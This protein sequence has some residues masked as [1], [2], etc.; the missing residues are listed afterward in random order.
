MIPCYNEATRLDVGAF[1]DF[2]RAYPAL[3]LL[4]VD[5]GSTDGTAAVLESLWS[6]SPESFE[7]LRLPRNRGKAEAVRLGI[8]AALRDLPRYVGFWDADLATPLEALLDF[9]RVLEERPWIELAVGS[10]V[11]LLGRDIARHRSRHYL[12]RVFATITSLVLDLRVYDTQCGAKI[13]RV[14][15][16]TAELFREPFRARWIFDVELFARLVRLR[17]TAGRPPVERIVYEVA[18]ASWRDV[19]GSRLRKRD[20]LTAVLDLA[21]IYRWLRLAHVP[22]APLAASTGSEDGAG[23]IRD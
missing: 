8:R 17:R 22:A 20:F 2:T 15:E 11:Q 3:R 10:R 5:D 16:D 13:F 14:T 6:H 18:L 23:G 21:R 1:L 4:L 12:G 19:A 9:Y 7:V